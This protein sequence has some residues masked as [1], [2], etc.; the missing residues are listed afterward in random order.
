M[1]WIESGLQADDRAFSWLG[2]RIEPDDEG[3]GDAPALGVL[4]SPAKT[5]RSWA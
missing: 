4:A 3:S 1:E 5:G 2:Y